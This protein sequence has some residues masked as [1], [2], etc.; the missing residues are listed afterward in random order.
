MDHFSISWVAT[1]AACA[2]RIPREALVA[3][4]TEISEI[5]T[6]AVKKMAPAT[7]ASRRVNPR[8]L[9]TPGLIAL[10]LGR[11]IVE[12][13]DGAD[14]HRI[15]DVADRDAVREDDRPGGDRYLPVHVEADREGCRLQHPRAGHHDE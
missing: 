3:P 5:A 4:R 9:R 1:R 10:N 14:D 12:E 8:G 15:G 7:S 11:S 13:D 6:T 2:Y